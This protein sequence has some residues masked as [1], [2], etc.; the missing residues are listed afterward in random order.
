MLNKLLLVSTNRGA[1]PMVGCLPFPRLS[2]FSELLACLL[3][4]HARETEEVF[5]KDLALR[6]FGYLWVA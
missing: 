3:K 1:S 5:T 6:L 2:R 4:V